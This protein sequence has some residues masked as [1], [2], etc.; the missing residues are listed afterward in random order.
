MTS[1]NG[2]G[3]HG[4]AERL[5]RLVASVLNVSADELTDE[6]SP[7]TVTSWDSLNHLNLI[8]A[9]E[10]E[11]GIG[12]SPEDAMDMSNVALIRAVLREHGVEV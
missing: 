3:N 4:G 8:L 1:D 5:Y 9:V 7:E 2:N 12:L 10:G 11:F 6:S